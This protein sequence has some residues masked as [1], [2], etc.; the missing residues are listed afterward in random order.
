MYGIRGPWHR[1]TGKFPA[2]LVPYAA[3]RTSNDYGD[4][5]IMKISAVI[6]AF[7]LVA[8]APAA[9]AEGNVEAGKIKAETCKGCHGIANYSNTYPTYRVPKI[10]GQHAT[11]IEAALK[12]YRTGE[13]QHPTM[14]AQASAMSDQDIADIS[15]YFASLELSGQA[16]SST[17]GNAASGQEKVNAKGCVSCHGPDGISPAPQNPVL[18]GQYPDYLL[19]VLKAYK[20]G[21]RKNPIMAGMAGQLSEEDMQDLAAW[22]AA[23]QSKLKILPKD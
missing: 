17:F 19:H 10:G 22:F 20:D 5:N 12:A 1:G 9:L 7:A 11:Y 14:S 16:E 3:L 4:G 6:A 8:A 18:A 13:R 15:A 2:I 21:T 23:Q